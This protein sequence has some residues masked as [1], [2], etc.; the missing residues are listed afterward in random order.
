MSKPFWPVAAI[1]VCTHRAYTTGGT[2]SFLDELRPNNDDTKPN[3]RLPALMLRG[4]SSVGDGKI[5]ARPGAEELLSSAL[6]GGVNSG[7]GVVLNEVRDYKLCQHQAFS[8]HLS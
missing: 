2:F 6:A 1:D 3:F 4:L 7:I 8:V 5:V